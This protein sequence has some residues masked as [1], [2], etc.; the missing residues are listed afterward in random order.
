MLVELPGVIILGV[1]DN[2]VN[3]DFA[4]YGAAECI[5]QKQAAQAASA[6]PQVDRQAAEK[7]GGYLRVPWQ[8]FVGRKI[9]QKDTGR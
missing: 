2:S 9:G 5:D 6:M 4:A 8:L 1:D 7:H 3:R